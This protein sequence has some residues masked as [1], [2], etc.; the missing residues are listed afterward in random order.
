MGSVMSVKCAQLVSPLYSSVTCLT[1]LQ[2]DREV[3]RPIIKYLL[4]V[5]I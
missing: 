3:T 4:M 2:Y 1:F 5:A